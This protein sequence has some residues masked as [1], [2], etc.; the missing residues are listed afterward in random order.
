MDGKSGSIES[1]PCKVDAFHFY[2][3]IV[4]IDYINYHVQLHLSVN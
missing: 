4:F 1:R 2:D 3:N